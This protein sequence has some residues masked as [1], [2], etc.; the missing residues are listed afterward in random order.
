MQLA[1]STFGADYSSEVLVWRRSPEG[2]LVCSPSS[3]SAMILSCA[4]VLPGR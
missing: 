4:S 2:R 3:L 1:S